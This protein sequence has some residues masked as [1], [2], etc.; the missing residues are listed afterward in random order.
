MTAKYTGMNQGGTGTVSDSDHLWQSVK[1]VL[2]T[3]LGSRVC[4][5]RTAVCYLICWTPQKTKQRVFR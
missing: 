3:P 5:G 4:A 2:L 1:D